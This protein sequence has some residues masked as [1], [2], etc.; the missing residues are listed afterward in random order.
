MIRTFCD[1]HTKKKRI[2]VRRA[3]Y[4]NTRELKYVT[5]GLVFYFAKMVALLLC[6]VYGHYSG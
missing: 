6:M 1:I 2:P 5:Q 4:R 3:M